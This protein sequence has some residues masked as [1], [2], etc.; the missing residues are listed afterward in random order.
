LLTSTAAG[1]GAA[2]FA[3]EKPAAKQ[4]TRDDGGVIV[5]EGPTQISEDAAASTAAAT[6][7][8]YEFTQPEFYTR[9]IVIEHDERGRGKI[10]FERKNEMSALTEPIELSEVALGRIASHWNALRFLESQDS[11]QASKQFPHLGTM[12]LKM[13]RGT[14][15]RTAEFNWTSNR[16]VS[17][18]IDEY[19][20]IGEQA[21]FIFDIKLAREMQPLEAP[22]IM[23]RLEMLLSRNGISDARQILPLLEDLT[24]D[25]R[26][27][28]IARNQAD[29]LV[30]KIKKLKT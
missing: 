22:K 25:E 20:R 11:Y 3:Q 7:Y 27:P 15:A 4:N 10:T 23:S 26:I 16:S 1:G 13:Q 8:S 5:A 6:A 12:R 30:K 17:S 29:R 2:L 24:T 9:H 19:R 14:A 21:I 18:L 28:L